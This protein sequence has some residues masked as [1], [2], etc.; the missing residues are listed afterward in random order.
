MI[1]RLII[2][3]IT[4]SRQMKQTNKMCLG[5]GRYTAVSSKTKERR[6][7]C[8][9]CIRPCLLL[10][11]RR[12]LGDGLTRGD[13][14]RSKNG[15]SLWGGTHVPRIPCCRVGMYHCADRK[16]Q[17]RK[18]AKRERERDCVEVKRERKRL[19]RGKEMILGERKVGK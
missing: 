14:A 10:Q 7:M 11:T 12:A 4:M 18:F 19:C 15:G 6:L 17:G 9:L 3:I 5:R 16:S 1:T 2:M 13:V 8:T